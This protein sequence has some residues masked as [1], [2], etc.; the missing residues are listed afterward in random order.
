MI[1]SLWNINIHLWYT[2]HK[3]TF[4]SVMCEELG[5]ARMCSDVVKLYST[6][7][8]RGN[9]AV[10]RWLIKLQNSVW[11]SGAGCV[12]HSFYSFAHTFLALLF[13]PL[14]LYK[15]LTFLYAQVPSSSVSSYFTRAVQSLMDHP[16]NTDFHE[17][18]WFCLCNIVCAD[19][20]VGVIDLFY[21][22]LHKSLCRQISVSCRPAIIK[23]S[24][25]WWILTSLNASLIS[26]V[27]VTLYE[28]VLFC[29]G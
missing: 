27:N 23:W 16:H 11:L 28:D 4:A 25:K 7:A 20:N 9:C 6:K 21:S 18:L 14:P 24:R 29:T 12:A 22:D 2:N 3:K 13:Y 10:R 1:Y 19:I 15:S 8:V 26:G 5:V 17:L